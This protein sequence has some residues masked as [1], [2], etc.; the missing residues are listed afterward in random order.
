[1]QMPNT[2]TTRGAEISLTSCSCCANGP[3][4]AMHSGPML[5]ERLLAGIRPATRVEPTSGPRAKRQRGR[6]GKAP[7]R[8][9]VHH[10]IIPP[11]YISLVGADRI[12]RQSGGRAPHAIAA[13]SPQGAVQIMDE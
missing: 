5:P 6:A 13:W 3:S 4:A 9:D 8:I 7:H 1:M 12:F 2:V 10:H 11:A